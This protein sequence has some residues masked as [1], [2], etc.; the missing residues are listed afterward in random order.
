MTTHTFVIYKEK[1][2]KNRHPVI[3]FID[4]GKKQTM[5]LI[6]PGSCVLYLSVY[7]RLTVHIHKASWLPAHINP[8]PAL[9]SFLAQKQLLSTTHCFR[10]YPDV[11]HF[12]ACSA[13]NTK[14]LQDKVIT[15]MKNLELRLCSYFFQI[16]RSKQY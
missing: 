2:R 10:Y 16:K 11:P 12:A 6:Y 13:C 3:T 4:F 7:L 5:I 9:P 8:L 1:K 15:E 14:R